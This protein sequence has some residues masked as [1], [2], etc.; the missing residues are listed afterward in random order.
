VAHGYPAAAVA[1]AYVLRNPAITSVV[2]GIR[3]REQLEDALKAVN[4]FVLGQEAYEQLQHSINAGTYL[5]H[6]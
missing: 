3:T 5:D 2:A 4:G 1:I 6:R